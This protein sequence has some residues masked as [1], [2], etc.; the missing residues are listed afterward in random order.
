MIL[1]DGE[2]TLARVEIVVFNV[3]VL[4]RIQD[5]LITLIST[6]RVS[7]SYANQYASDKARFDITYLTSCPR[8][9]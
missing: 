8:P 5:A 1:I 6:L 7:E 3:S 9:A 4:A 2:I